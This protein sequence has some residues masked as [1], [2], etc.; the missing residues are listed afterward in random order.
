MEVYDNRY[1][2]CRDGRVNIYISMSQIMYERQTR[3][4]MKVITDMD[5]GNFTRF[6]TIIYSKSHANHRSIGP[7]ARSNT[8]ESSVVELPD[9]TLMLNKHDNGKR[10]KYEHNVRSLTTVIN[11][12]RSW[13]VHASI[14]SD[15]PEPAY[16]TDWVGSEILISRKR[17]SVLFFGNLNDK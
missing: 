4:P 1:S 9:D 15:I 6:A 3:E 12:D 16:N 10:K 7:R 8:T 17:Q 13:K 5:G 14:N 11:L 2:N